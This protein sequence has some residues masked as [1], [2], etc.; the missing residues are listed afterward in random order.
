VPIVPLETLFLDP[1]NDVLILP[2]TNA[3]EVAA[4]LQPLRQ[5][6]TQLWTPVPRM[7]RL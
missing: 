6:G 2:W 5:F 1:P 3:A 7:A 4:P